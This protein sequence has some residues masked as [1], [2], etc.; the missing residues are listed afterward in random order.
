[1]E[2]QH[3]QPPRRRKRRRSKKYYRMRMLRRIFIC[4][5]IVIG[6]LLIFGIVQLIRFL[7]PDKEDAKDSSKDQ[8]NVEAQEH[9]AEILNVGDIVLHSPFIESSK[10]T[11]D[12]Q[13]YDFSSIFTYVKD[14]YESADFSVIS[15]EAAIT[16]DN[17]S[18]Y[19]M[20]HT[21][22]DL[23]TNLKDSGIDMC[24]MANNHIYDN[25]DD[26]L[27]TTVDAMKDNSMLY[28]GIQENANDVTYQIQDING[29]KVGMFNYVYETGTPGDVAINGISV[30]SESA[31]KIN[32][33]NYDDLDTFYSE[34]ENG[35]QEMEEAGVEYT[36]AYMHWGIE[37][38]TVESDYQDEIAQELCEL[39]IDA[40]IGGHPH[41]IQ[42]VDLLTNAAGDHK[43]V[44]AYS[45]G[46]TL[47]NQRQEL[48]DSMPTGET[49]DGLT[50]RLSLK[51]TDDG[52][53][54][55]VSVD[56]IPTW[57][58]KSTASGSAEYYIFPL[59]DPEKIVEEAAGF[60]IASDVENSLARTNA[61]IGE[62]VKKVQ[63]AL[64][65]TNE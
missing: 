50:V 43:M 46:N 45:L 18:G 20:F 54:S 39:G 24:L 3:Q 4:G 13:N 22:A 8:T 47:S 57:V 56:F 63:A 26:G 40:L 5:F 61:I 6:L 16:E 44:C 17:F 25:F 9:T 27:V 31:A 32:S 19:P 42:P 37:Y 64:P 41:V 53:V 10:Y 7:I 29:I 34:I 28:I 11:S 12:G 59:D 2:Q 62:G 21:P 55:L 60:D 23:V 58:Y 15:I 35:L 38:Q 1:M 14:D 65:I 51:Q 30:S 36:I 49:E 48:M 33:F 52:P